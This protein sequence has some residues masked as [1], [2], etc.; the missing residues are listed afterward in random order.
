VALPL[1]SSLNAWSIHP[2][3]GPDRP[4]PEMAWFK[5]ELLYRQA[6]D[7]LAPRLTA[8]SRLA[9]GDVGV[10]GFYTPARILDTVGLNS[11]ESLRYY[12][13]DKQYYVINYA[14]PADLILDERPDYVV[15]LEVYARLT[16]LQDP[17]FSQQYT[18]LRTLPTDIY[19]SRGMLIFA[20]NP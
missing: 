3:H 13:L 1:C 16:L 6:A 14:I 8:S 7:Y 15:I 9:A 11:P 19:G 5:L 20:R 18:L 12:P 10:L 4:A 17:R 2:D